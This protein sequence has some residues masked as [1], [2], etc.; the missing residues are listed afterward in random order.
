M[1]DEK[2]LKD[3]TEGQKEIWFSQQIIHNSPRYNTAE[4]VDIPGA[5][6]K[7]YFASSVVAIL[8]NVKHLNAGFSLSNG[9]LSQEISFENKI[10][11]RFL[12]FSKETNPQITLNNWIHNDLS[13]PVSLC[14][15]PLYLS[16]L[17]KIA[18]DHYKWYLRSHH[19]LMD[20]FSNGL[21]INSVAEYYS[22]KESRDRIVLGGCSELDAIIC[23]EKKYSE[24]ARFINDRAF[25]AEYCSEI[26][27][28]ARL[29]S[30]HGGICD[31][32]VRENIKLSADVFS[33]IKKR[34]KE[35][36][37][38]WPVIFMTI[39]SSFIDW[40]NRSNKN[41]CIGVPFMNRETREDLRTPGMTVNILPLNIKF[42]NMEKFKDRANAVDKE[43]RK[44]KPHS[45]YRGMNLLRLKNEGEPLFGPVINIMPF[46]ENLLFDDIV[47][48]TDNL[49]SGP[50]DDLALRVVP[51]GSSEL[52][53]LNIFIDGN[54]CVYSKQSMKLIAREIE[55][56]LCELSSSIQENILEFYEKKESEIIYQLVPGPQETFP[57]E[58]I[59]SRLE[60]TISTYPD[61]LALIAQGEELT[62]R[63]LGE[64]VSNA[65]INLI[66]HGIE[67]GDIVAIYM[68]RCA[69]TLVLMLALISVGATNLILDVDNPVNRNN[70]ILSSCK[71]KMLIYHVT[72]ASSAKELNIVTRCYYKELLATARNK[73]KK[74]EV[75]GNDGCF[76]IFTSGTTGEPKG[77]LL[78]HESIYWFICSASNEYGL[79][80][81]DRMLQ[82]S[83]LYFDACI[84]EIFI[85]LFIGGTLVL[86]NKE[87]GD[88]LDAFLDYIIRHN[89]TVLDLPTTFWHT[90][91]VALSHQKR[92]FPASIRKI[93][94]GGEA[95]S[96][97]RLTQWFTLVKSDAEIINTYGPTEGTVVFTCKKIDRKVAGNGLLAKS[98]GRPLAGLNC[99]ILD[100]NQ[101]PVLPGV[102]GELYLIGPTLAAGYINSPKETAARFTQLLING[103]MLRTYRTGDLVSLAENGEIIYIGRKDN[104]TKLRGYR[105]DL[106]EIRDCVLAV[107]GV[108]EARA[109][110]KNK[111]ILSLY[112]SLTDENISQGIIADRLRA[113][114][115]G[116]AQP[117]NIVIIKE[118]P[119]TISGKINEKQ[120]IIYDPQKENKDVGYQIS[121]FEANVIAVWQEVLEI[122]D[123]APDS[124]FNSFGGSS[125]NIFAIREKLLIKGIDI[126]V[127]I[128]IENDTVHEIYADWKL[129]IDLECKR[130]K[131]QECVV[132]LGRSIRKNSIWAI[133]PYSGRV[134]CY[135]KIAVS[136]A[137]YINIQAIQAP[138]V[139][140]V[141]VQN[142]SLDE[143]ADFYIS[144]IKKSQ[145]EGPY[146][147]IGY[148]LGGILS[149]I[150]SEKMLALGE[151][152]F[153]VGLIDSM[154]P[155]EGKKTENQFDAMVIKNLGKNYLD[156]IAHLDAESQ[157]CLVA[158]RLVVN[159]HV[160]FM[161]YEQLIP[162][163]KYGRECSHYQPVTLRKYISEVPVYH[164]SFSAEPAA[165]SVWTGGK[166]KSYHYNGAH[167]NVINELEQVGAINDIVSDVRRSLSTWN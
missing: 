27:N 38:S 128:L 44:I 111:K 108:K 118:F 4:I 22:E 80:R 52:S 135:K 46:Y 156:E 127:K 150:I 25:W 62:Y 37:C 49:Y 157:V 140:G 54:P 87:C 30:S 72:S 3:L 10:N 81:S 16:C 1:R 41:I 93:I 67:S 104:Q 145:P 137:E 88:S 82:F 167:D 117:N 133:H 78:T 15:P 74:V 12:D 123:I 84:E 141:D 60:K 5:I 166:G 126:P 73:P 86:R 92:N 121:E 11:H 116:Y 19:I 154:P 114:L 94:I 13:Q 50:V 17:I 85:P 32:V 101:R 43:L 120:L 29:S 129:W 160:R 79:I 134:D 147:F 21:L 90:L 65:H 70:H 125:L 139:A 113:F 162:V 36:N 112:V 91:T 28:V 68:P 163:L 124:S 98:I 151:P 48:E 7:N 55:Q 106:N 40:K 83:S 161:S 76:I 148:S 158:E 109:V 100:E 51:D 71:V 164:Y 42:K 102:E 119:L 64:R 107:P 143:L 35:C 53:S 75:A 34:G 95:V 63:E 155:A 146:G 132:A 2:Y 152:I 99:L 131:G 14:S 59:I 138:Y 6:D 159:G 9:V 142:N 136:L 23:T 77:V 115:P 149:Y 18:D 66:D 47:A 130:F 26:R 57:F 8:S 69:D 39:V 31:T 96:S 89:I 122:A 103:V 165:W 56:W 45:R 24:S 97:E 144:V 105:I 20:G 33:S 61:S 58:S 110:I 153:Y